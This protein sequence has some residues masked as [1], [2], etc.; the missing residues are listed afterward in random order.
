M[1]F[2]WILPVGYTG[3]VLLAQAT[4]IGNDTHTVSFSHQRTSVGVAVTTEILKNFPISGSDSANL[5]A[6]KLVLESSDVLVFS[7]NTSTNIKF[8]GS[9]LET[10]N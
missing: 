7:S 3:V 1:I 2:V 4:N 10:L 9:M 5:L 8:I 6:G